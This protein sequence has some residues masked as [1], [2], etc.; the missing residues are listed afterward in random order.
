VTDAITVRRALETSGLV[1]V[2]A[3]VLLGHVLC[4]DRAWLAAH[5]T[6]TIPAAQAD[7]FFALAKRRRDGEPVAYLTGTREFWG[8]PIAVSPVVLIPRPE[9]ETLVEMALAWFPADRETRVLDLGTGSGAIALAIAHERPR[10]LVLATDIS[11]AALSVARDNARRLQIA[12]IEFARSDWFA[13]LPSPFQDQR[14]DLIVCNPP[15]VEAGDAHLSTGDL[16]FEPA[17][18]LSPGDDGLLA[19]RRIV[20]GAP[21]HLVAGGALIVEHG[22]DQED[23][24]R[25]LFAEAGFT[26]V[27]SA[28]D[29]AGIPRVVGGRG[30]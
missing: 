26:D 11:E 20:A 22:Y 14:F 3:R 12:N 15:Y 7:E 1:A 23:A 4:K 28:R 21:E 29:L 30:H 10:F 13:A 17:V 6:E 25:A 19:I 5:A 8:L 24:V 9:T 18:A 16:Q 2:D 27:T